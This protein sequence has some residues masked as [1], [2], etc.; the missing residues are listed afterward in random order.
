M[1][2]QIGEIERRR[3]QDTLDFKKATGNVENS[4]LGS[5]MM[6]HSRYEPR[7]YVQELQ[8]QMQQDNAKRR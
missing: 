1:R 2:Q 6:H 4:M 7:A 5:M 8:Q 3:S